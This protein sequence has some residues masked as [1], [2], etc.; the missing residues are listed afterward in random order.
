MEQNLNLQNNSKKRNLSLDIL[1]ILSM[2]MVIILHTKTYGL[3]D[4]T[5]VPYSSVY[6]VVLIFYIFS[7]VAVNC[8]VLISGYFSNITPPEPKKL[9]KLWVQVEIFSVGIYFILKNLKFR[10]IIEILK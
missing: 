6:W 3:R 8:F 5:L 7:L 9:L 4:A 2:I 1:K 10:D